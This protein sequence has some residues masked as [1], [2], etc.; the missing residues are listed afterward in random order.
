MATYPREELVRQVLLRLGVLDST[1]AP[2]A[3]DAADVGR[4]AKTVMEDLYTEGKL[5]FDIQGD[6]PARYLTHLSYVIAEPMIA[7][8]GAFQ[9]EA[10][11]VRNAEIGRRA[12]NRLNATTYQGAVVPSDY[13]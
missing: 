6:I 11:I 9:R 7:D 5:P 10:N 3:E 13:F 12:I 2:E 1:E 4:M 8:Y